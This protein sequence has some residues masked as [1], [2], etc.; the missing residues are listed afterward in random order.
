M[1]ISTMYAILYCIVWPFFNLFHP[2][3][4]IGRENVPEGAALLCPNHTRDSDPLF[5][6]FAL[7]LSCR[8]RVMA[9]KQILDV[10]VVGYLLK[11]A[12]IFAVAREKTDV[13]AIKTALNCLKEGAKLMIFPEGTRHKDGVLGKAKTGVA[14]MAA[15]TGAAIVPVYI[16]AKKKWF[17]RTPVVF[18][19]AFYP[20]FTTRHGTAEEYDAVSEELMARIDALRDKAQ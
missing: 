7:T 4:A 10:P 20:T 19:E 16:P 15:R 6:A 13:I 3:R 2:C 17:R 9:K 1:K 14:M 5:V 12:G 18:G 11:K 8:P